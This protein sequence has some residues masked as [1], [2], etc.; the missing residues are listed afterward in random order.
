MNPIVLVVAGSIAFAV[1][2]IALLRWATRHSGALGDLFLDTVLATP[3]IALFVIL[4]FVLIGLAGMLGA[5]LWPVSVV[6][7]S[8]VFG[9]YRDSERRALA[10]LLAVAAEQGVSLSA[11]ARAFAEECWGP[12]SRRARRLADMLEA[13]MPLPE[14]LVESRV[15]LPT[16]AQVAIA[17]ASEWGG[18]T[19]AVKDA[20]SVA[21][22]VEP[23]SRDVAGKVAYLAAIVLYATGIVT[24]LFYRIIPQYIKIYEDFEIELPFVTQFVIWIGAEVVKNPLL[25]VLFYLG[26]GACAWMILG[27][28]VGAARWEPPLV[29]R[30]W[31][32]LDQAVVLRSLAQAVDQGRPMP[33]AIGS[34]ARLYPK[35]HIRRRLSRT[36]RRA[37]DGG[38]WR[39]SLEQSGLLRTAEGDVLR[40][41]ER[42]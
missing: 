1:L 13:G 7:A 2:V 29:R 4:F 41:A 9:R 16:D 8:M 24:Y 28:Y 30:L 38:D 20:T 31:R 21:V 35:R 27:H 14:A 39:A 10:R 3:W 42:G 22:Q 26:L 18:L 5:L 15:H 12:V 23:I 40:S 6:V 19:A 17:T 32:R 11:A 37:T 25:A 36:A 34:L 33:A